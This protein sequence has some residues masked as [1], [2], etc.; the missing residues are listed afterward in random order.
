M[1]TSKFFTPRMQNTLLSNERNFMASMAISKCLYCMIILKSSHF[2]PILNRNYS[3]ISI[4]IRTV[5]QFA[6]STMIT[7]FKSSSDSFWTFLSQISKPLTP[8]ARQPIDSSLKST[9]VC[10][11]L[12]LAHNDACFLCYIYTIIHWFNA[13]VILVRLYLILKAIQ[14]NKLI[15]WLQR[16]H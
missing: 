15:Q 7:I 16:Y 2:T 10:R 1:Q 4:I 6:V 13:Q 8:V 11:E 5:K 14:I 9:F 12:S 3:K